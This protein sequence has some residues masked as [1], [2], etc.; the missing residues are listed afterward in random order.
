LRRLDYYIDELVGYDDLFL[1]CF[2][3]VSPPSD[4]DENGK[5]CTAHIVTLHGNQ[6]IDTAKS[7]ALSVVNANQYPRRDRE[8]KRIFRVVPL[9]H[10]RRV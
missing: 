9:G 10:P 7:G 6:I 3:S 4:P 5:L 8:T 2:Y 1:L